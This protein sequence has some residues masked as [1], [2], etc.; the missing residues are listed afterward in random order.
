FSTRS[1]P[2]IRL[3]ASPLRAATRQSPT[4]PR[5]SVAPITEGPSGPQAGGAGSAA[6]RGEAAR[7]TAA[8]RNPERPD[9]AAEGVAA[10]A[11][12]VGDGA[13]VRRERGQHDGPG[14]RRELLGRPALDGNPPEGA[15][16]VVVTT[17]VARRDQYERAAA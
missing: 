4:S 5:S 16:V 12:Q 7:V 10:G 6:R 15:R 11:R 8:R 17:V 9:V 1:P 2:T 13:A 14:R 3:G